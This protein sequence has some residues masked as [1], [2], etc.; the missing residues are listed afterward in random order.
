MQLAEELSKVA[1]QLNDDI[2]LAR[3]TH[4][5]TVAINTRKAR[6]LLAMF[7]TDCRLTVLVHLLIYL[8]EAAK[9]SLARRSYHPSR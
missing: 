2:G 7:Q 8:S 6:S 3:R 9:V 5:A 4:A 1:V